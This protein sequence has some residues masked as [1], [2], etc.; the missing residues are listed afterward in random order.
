MSKFF[1]LLKVNISL[2]VVQ[3]NIGRLTRNRK[4]GLSSMYMLLFSAIL[5]M[6]YMGW[7]DTMLYKSVG[8]Y[9]FGWLLVAMGLVMVSLFTLA[10]GIYTVNSVLFESQDLDQLFSYPISPKQIMFSKL[11]ALVAENWIIGLAFYLPALAVYSYHVKPDPAF[12]IYALLGFICLPLIPVCLFIL[13]A[14]F[15]NLVVSGKRAKNAINAILTFGLIFAASFGIQE[16][17]TSIKVSNLNFS[18]LIGSF[19]NFYPPLGY[20]TSG[21]V[22]ENPGDLMIGLAWN[23]LPFV[24]LCVVLSFGY[25]ALWSRSTAVSKSKG[26]ALSFGIHSPFSTLVQ[27][28]FARFFSS[29]M[30]ILNSS[31]GMI[32]MT[33]FAV[34]SATGGARLQDLESLFPGNM[35]VLFV[36]LLFGFVLVI[37]NTT[38]PSIS[39]EGRNLWIIKSWPVG[40][41]E[42]L[43]AKLI[44]HLAVTLPLLAVNCVIVGFTMK[45]NII[46]SLIVFLLCALFATLSGL[47]G[48]IFNLYF[49]RFDFF[50]DTQVVKNSASVLLTYLAMAVILGVFAGIY[51]LLRANIVQACFLVC[52]G[53]ALVSFTVAAALFVFT[54]GKNLFRT[55]I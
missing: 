40:E 21:I 5:I 28:E 11:M 15:L 54:R 42:I 36:L 50:N 6:A 51:W 38:A 29:V 18:D 24:V 23:I 12:Y 13:F 55:V 32:L 49:H 17:I 31:I 2:A 7:I 14:Y 26:K 45:L 34:L 41:G 46:D 44:V 52:V 37:T 4:R 39:L 19:K 22:K 53:V 48:L 20:L 35:K 1:E 33:L 25:K 16:M 30:Y 10:T 47:I 8:P 9:G 43:M 27:K 3:L